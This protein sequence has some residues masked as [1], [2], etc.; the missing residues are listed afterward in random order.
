MM[1]HK[2]SKLALF[3]N[4]TMLTPGV[5]FLL[6]TIVH[7]FQL[8]GCKMNIKESLLSVANKWI[9][10]LEYMPIANSPSQGNRDSR[11]TSM[12]SCA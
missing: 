8:C 10:R 9:P 1:G 2:I 7:I 4:A 11:H 5:L 12:H 6:H 3:Y